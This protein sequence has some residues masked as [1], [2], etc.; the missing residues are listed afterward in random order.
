MSR[1]LITLLSLTLTVSFYFGYKIFFGHKESS[2]CKV[3]PVSEEMEV[4]Y[5]PS[6]SYDMQKHKVFLDSKD[7]IQ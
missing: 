7:F 4:I 5:I 2:H 3:T 1:Y 6:K